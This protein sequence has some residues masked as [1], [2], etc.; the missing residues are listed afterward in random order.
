[1]TDRQPP[2][3]GGE[4][5][6]LVVVS[7]SRALARA[8][9][10][11]AGEMLHGRPVRIEVAAGLDET[12]FGTDAGRI[13]E[14]VTAADR[15]S[16]V[17]VLMDLGSAV[18]SAELAL[19]LLDDA[20]RERVL[21]C[22][23]PLVEGLVVAAVAAAGGAGRDEVA[24]E[25][26]GALAGKISHLGVPAPAPPAD[27]PGPGGPDAVFTVTNPHGLHARPAARVVQAVRMLDARVTL[28]NRTTGSAWVPASSLSKV[29]TLGVLCG[30]EVE[31]RVGGAQAREALD[32]L[33]ALAAR[34]FDEGPAPAVE[35]PAAAPAGRPLP[36]SPGVGIGPAWSVP[37]TPVEV[38]VAPPADDPAVEWRRLK[39]AIA[40]VRRAVQRI[41]AGAVR[42]VGEPAAA[43][44]DAHLL[45][46][47]DADL[48]AD[49]RALVDG[50]RSAAA[51]WSATLGRVG[52]ELGALSDP[53]MAA[54]AADVAAVGDQVLR[55]LL[56]VTRGDPSP[57]GVLVT[58][59]LTPA[60]AADLD[61][62]RVTAVVQAFGSPSAHSAILLRA[63]GIPAVVGAGAEVLGVADGTLLA[64]D[65]GRG[66]VVV[67]PS[68][69]VQEAFRERA[70]DLARRAADALAHAS[71]PAVTRD[72]VEVAVGANV[73]SADDARAAAAAG[74]DLAGLVRTEFLFLG[75]D[76]APDVDEQE[77]VYR[78][79]ADALH[80]RRITLR[81]LDVG[82]D[83][84]LGYLPTAPEANPFLGVRGIRLSLAR[85]QL[86][87]DQLLAVVRVAHDVPVDLMFPMVGTLDE[88]LAARALLDDAVTLAGRG[89]PAGLR[90]GIMVEVPAAALKARAFAPH[91]DFFSVGTNDLTQYALAAER[92][93][94][95]VAAVADP[96]DPGLLQLVG[97]VCRAGRP[98]AVC[99][100]LAAD[101]RATA[102][103]VGLGVRELSVAPR[104]VPGVK[105]AVRALDGREAAA[106]AAA[107]L[108][109]P[110][111]AAVR[112]LLEAE[113]S[114]GGR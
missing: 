14:A 47:D 97:A 29:A 64:V 27:D 100:E 85:P 95:A 61:R 39:E 90:V 50:G 114:R 43:I 37:A 94:D 51:A 42:E 25:A 10:A 40:T 101:E 71:S 87:A 108:D 83:K 16:G 31:V 9:V 48:L 18:L 30:H 58:G 93:N 88:L 20:A 36:A 35:R 112:L 11:L 17:V 89:A 59:D 62:E 33:L 81:T 23:A 41:R 67:D 55:A 76:A 13:L 4:T 110:T 19:E 96:F 8:A 32:H 68:A 74:A 34:D 12:T 78:G 49:V 56:G 66:E 72:G 77:A 113:P 84:P 86:L 92:G 28:R 106:T 79:I 3:P 45:L 46:L 109:A 5:V 57:T 6:G 82:G 70:A 15:G 22:P 2:G 73:G 102:L 7:H 24:A 111:A 26:G 44:F 54:R 21:L 60:E 38:P 99:G 63:R 103:L 107:A 91:V 69:R 1:M 80:G 75:R 98:V 105:Q 52:A 104:A 65:G 53:Y